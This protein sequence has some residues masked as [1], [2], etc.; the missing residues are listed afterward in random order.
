MKGM[1]LALASRSHSSVLIERGSEK[2]FPA[3]TRRFHASKILKV[4][5]FW[6]FFFVLRRSIK[7]LKT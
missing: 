1:I 6:V 2:G 3:V 4:V 7:D 5:F